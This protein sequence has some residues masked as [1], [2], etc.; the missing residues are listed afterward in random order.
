M[1]DSLA[2]W[3]KGQFTPLFQK[4]TESADSDV[5]STLGSTFKPDAR[6]IYNHQS[7]DLAKFGDDLN[8]SGFAVTRTD[9]E[10]KEI[11]ATPNESD[12]SGTQAGIVAGY[13]VVTR[14]MK[15]RI[16]AAPARTL[17]HCFFSAKVE[18]G[19]QTEQGPG[20]RLISELFITSISKQAPIHLQGIPVSWL[21]RA[22]LILPNLI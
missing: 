4:N 12:G 9:V 7:I 16:R 20:N 8:Q 18:E 3:V 21:D 13:F 1:S 10:W 5:S 22:S 17:Q 15:F 14:S 6:I 11:F 2:D 19:T